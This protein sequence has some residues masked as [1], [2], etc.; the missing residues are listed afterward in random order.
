MIIRAITKASKKVVDKYAVY[1][2]DG[3]CLTL[4][5]N[6]DSPQGVS[7]MSEYYG[8]NDSDFETGRVGDEQMINWFELPVVVQAHIEK[9]IRQAQEK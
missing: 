9:R 6:P 7:Q 5:S 8:I 2:W 1:F 3:T 4:S